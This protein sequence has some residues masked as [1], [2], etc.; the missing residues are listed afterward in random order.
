MT[1]VFPFDDFE[2]GVRDAI[3][4]ADAEFDRALGA[5]KLAEIWCAL[6]RLSV[7]AEARMRFAL[8]ATKDLPLAACPTWLEEGLNSIVITRPRFRTE[9]SVLN[10]T[11][12]IAQAFL[13]THPDAV[14][15]LEPSDDDCIAIRWDDADGLRFI[16]SRPTLR[17]PA[18]SA[19]AYRRSARFAPALECRHARLAHQLIEMPY[20]KAP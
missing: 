16:V 1:G 5:R 20:E 6:D 13:A 3:A 10:S 14:G 7:L 15:D 17:W 4:S 12:R 19:R 2:P 9:T 18:V 11:C 8:Y